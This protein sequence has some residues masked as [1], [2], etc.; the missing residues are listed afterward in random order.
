MSAADTNTLD[1][2]DPHRPVLY[3]RNGTLVFAIPYRDGFKAVID[4]MVEAHRTELASADRLIIDLRGNE[5]GSSSMTDA[6]G[7]YVS[8]KTDLPNPF[9]LD[10]SM[11]L[12]SPSQI[13][14]ARRGFGSDTSA[15]VRSL[16]RR[17]GIAPR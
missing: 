1:P 4:S 2:V 6:L 8:L 14:Y 17:N 5:G 3:K 15:F 12:S 16:V 13:S 10:K 7:P 9:P 11:I